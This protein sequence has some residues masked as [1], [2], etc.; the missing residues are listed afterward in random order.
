M[1]PICLLSLLL[2]SLLSSQA[3]Q[4]DTKF[5]RES[6]VKPVEVP[7]SA[8]DFV[9]GC[10]FAQRVRWY[11]EESQSGLSYEAKVKSEQGRFS[12]EFDESGQLQDVELTQDWDQVPEKARLAIQS[13]LLKRFTRHRIQKIQ[14]QWT[15]PEA[16]LQALIR[17]EATNELYTQKYEL[18]IRAQ[19]QADT[20]WY[21]MLFS[22]SGQL[23]NAATFRLRNTDNLDY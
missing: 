17:Q 3:Q 11:R 9:K 18:V 6:R 19:D 22:A 14:L 16:T 12:I 2:L 20:Q 7:A 5:E 21:E 10:Q 8:Q 1:K 23:E 13:Y 4:G 15:G